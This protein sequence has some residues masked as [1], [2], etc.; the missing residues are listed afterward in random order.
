MR[1]KVLII[2][3]NPMELCQNNGKTLL[4][5]FTGYG[6]ENLA[7]LYFYPSV[8]NTAEFDTFFRI[9]D[10]DILNRRLHRTTGAGSPVEAVDCALPPETEETARMGHMKK[11]PLLRLLRE[12]LWGSAWRSDALDRWL[13]TVAPDCIFFVA[14]DSLYSYAI[15][16]Y[17]RQRC[18]AKLVVYVGDDYIL[19]RQTLNPFREL[20]RRL[21]AKKMKQCVADA[22][23]F[24]TI[25]EKMRETYRQVLGK[26]S[27]L[28]VNMADSLKED[29]PQPTRASDRLLLA[30]LGG[31][32]YNRGKTLRRLG[33]TIARINAGGST[34]L[35]L[36]IY[37]NARLDE[38]QKAALEVPEASRFCGQ[39]DQA[40]VRRK[41]NEADILVHV[42]SFR[43]DN[44]ADV[45]LS[46]STKIPEYLSTGK[47]LLA[48]GPA[49]V[50]SMEYLK[51]LAWCVTDEGTLEEKLVKLAQ[52][53]SLRAELGARGLTAYAH[54]H[55]REVRQAALWNAIDR[56]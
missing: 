44:I 3:A 40:G 1:K 9:S 5:F 48:I 53:P 16:E 35:F 50:A 12:L 39:L 10:F 55:R 4:S 38:S 28:A 42:E 23:L 52:D 29:I 18:G 13:D 15:C 25:S 21:I 27:I 19:P 20:R 11:G 32:Q 14:G 26:D 56:L 41:V 30:Y 45:R 47:P 8:P 34:Q 17:V 37:S 49:E 7:Q 33:E 46:L 2:S 54:N 43:K 31:L 36:E 51:D 22:N 6:R 24:I